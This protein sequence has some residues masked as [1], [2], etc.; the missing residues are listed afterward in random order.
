MTIQ[1]FNTSCALVGVIDDYT[2]FTFLRSYSGVGDWTLVLSAQS[3]LADLIY[4]AAYIR[5]GPKRAGIITKIVDTWTAQEKTITVTGI[6]L[7]GLASKRL[8][9][10]PAGEGYLTFTGAP[11]A[12]IAALISSQITNPSD[13][14]RQIPGT[15]AAYSSGSDSY[16]YSGRYSVTADDIAIIAATY[17]V[18]W[19][20]DIENGRIVWHIFRGVDRT[21]AQAVHNR[22]MISQKLDSYAGSSYSEARHA[23]NTVVV[24][25]Q[26]E[27]ADR[28]IAV[29]N[30]ANT[31]LARTE[32]FVD[33]RDVTDAALLPQRGQEKLAELGD[34]ATFEP[35][36]E[37]GAFV[38]G[39]M[40]D[41]DLG[42]IGT[43]LEDD[44]NFRL[45]TITEVY[46]VGQPPLTFGFGYDGVSSIASALSGVSARVQALETED[47]II[48]PLAL[49]N[50]GTAAQD[51]AGACDNIG[52]LS[53]ATGGSVNG[54]I[55]ACYDYPV[56]SLT[57]TRTG[58]RGG[59]RETDTNVFFL[60]R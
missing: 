30:D 14:A 15:I 27:G 54:R 19:Y 57:S 40:I 7:K 33:A 24:A 16:S 45:A 59:M 29:V 3:P 42:D 56:V 2:S 37:Y 23:K 48:Y 36:P 26:G 25:G 52:A 35:T 6:E 51:A 44:V 31:G 21:A 60:S 13:T 53:K 46:E 39:Y 5:V 17:G 32:M 58:R 12:A 4:D 22:L 28:A 10:P 9:Y 1:L 47:P 8:V 11:E 41:Y 43:L 50:G 49:K 38:D 55:D 18:G 34:S 20:A